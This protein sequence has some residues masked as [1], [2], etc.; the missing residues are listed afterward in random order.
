M[1]KRPGRR[2]HR[3]RSAVAGTM[4]GTSRAKIDT[5]GAR[6]IDSPLSGPSR[7]TM[8]D[9]RFMS[10]WGKLFGAAA[11]F[12]IGGPLGAIFGG[13]AG[14]LADELKRPA[15]DPELEQDESYHESA[16]PRDPG[17]GFDART[18]E[19]PVA[20]TIAV[21]VLGAKLAKA[22]GQVTKDEVAAFKQIFHVPQNEAR[23]VG[24]L[25]NLAR[26]DARGYEPYAR[27]IARMFLGNPAV[28]EE[29]L[30]ALFHIAMADGTVG[31]EELIYLF[32]VSQIFGFDR[33][34]F[35]RIR[36]TWL[37]A[38]A[39]DPYALLGLTRDAT[40]EEVKTAHRKLVREN[41]PDMLVAQGMPE[42]FVEQANAVLAKVNDA[43]DRIR[44]ERGLS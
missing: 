29:L 35:E 31:D 4:A 34:R 7:W 5:I 38:G 2:W 10:I 15:G 1:P 26:R 41:H 39:D 19:K 20:F 16:T 17:V 9:R 21:V 44:K 3:R 25:F 37:G 13:L 36:A 8:R 40:D 32:S 30:N 24:R 18:S 42:D 12:A 14:H 6:V 28:L 27:Q 23:N 22:D 33:H 11:G 43:H